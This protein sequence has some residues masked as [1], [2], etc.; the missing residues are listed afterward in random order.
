MMLWSFW[1]VVHFVSIMGFMGITQFVLDGYRR[2]RQLLSRIR[3]STTTGDFFSVLPKDVHFRDF[4]L[5]YRNS[6][7]MACFEAFGALTSGKPIK[8][9]DAN[10]E[11]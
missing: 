4:E 10:L 7:A 3:G 6:D 1:E 9:G 2:H 11:T 5:E 8:G